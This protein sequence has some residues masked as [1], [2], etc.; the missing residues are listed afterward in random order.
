MGIEWIQR[1]GD[2]LPLAT[3]SNSVGK[4][5][6]NGRG[7]VG[8]CSLNYLLLLVDVVTPMA[9]LLVVFRFLLCHEN[10][11]IFRLQCTYSDIL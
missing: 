8:Q 3:G 9:L 2:G 6:G 1:R 10:L 11:M 4:L 7:G 5:S